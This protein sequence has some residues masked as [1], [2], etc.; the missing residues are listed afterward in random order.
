MALGLWW[1]IIRDIFF[2][3][4]ENLVV[5][6]P[7]NDWLTVTA[8]VDQGLIQEVTKGSRT[9]ST[10]LQASLVSVTVSVHDLTIRERLQS[11][12]LQY[13]KFVFK[14]EVAVTTA[15]YTQFTLAA[16]SHYCFFN[17][18]SLTSCSLELHR[19][20]EKSINSVCMAQFFGT[21]SPE[22][23]RGQL[24]FTSGTH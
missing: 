21:W 20:S 12:N 19:I 22:P 14:G 3:N 4:G 7:M 2:T 1:T 6:L 17:R 11:E 8:R 18:L 16:H 23:W 13:D 10:E 9:A 24:P 15:S 5:N